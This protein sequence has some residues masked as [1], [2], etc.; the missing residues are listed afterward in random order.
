M[1]Y[2]RPTS[3]WSKEKESISGSARFT[4]TAQLRELNSETGAELPKIAGAMAVM[5]CS[6]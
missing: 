4:E 1:A 6:D 5:K 3:H 2:N